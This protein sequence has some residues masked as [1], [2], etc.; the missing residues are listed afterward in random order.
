MSPIAYRDGFNEAIRNG[1]LKFLRKAK[2]TLGGEDFDVVDY[3][4][5][6]MDM[7]HVQCGDLVALDCY[8][9]VYSL[10]NPKTDSCGVRLVM[11]A[12]QC[13]HSGYDLNFV[14]DTAIE[15]VSP[16]SKRRKF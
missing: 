16:P 11:T 4:G 3:N 13:L 9:Q 15:V 1:K 7:S 10:K 8:L 14:K 5:N 6:P 2:D 12:V